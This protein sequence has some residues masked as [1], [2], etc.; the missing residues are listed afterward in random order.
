M[1]SKINDPTSEPIGQS[2][3]EKDQSI[4]EKK[5]VQEST[6]SQEL[7][8]VEGIKASRWE[9]SWPVIACGAGL[10]SDGYLNGVSLRLFE[11]VL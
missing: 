11:G 8:P 6:E 1:D 2:V 3:N 4:D 7:A 5:Y 10:F 9:R